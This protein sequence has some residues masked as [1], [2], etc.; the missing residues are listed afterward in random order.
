MLES[1]AIMTSGGVADFGDLVLVLGDFHVPF[2]AQDVPEK[3]KALLVPN[4]MKHILCTGNLCTRQTM[5]YLRTIAPNVHAVRGEFDEDSALPDHKIVEIG[6]F[7]V[8]IIHGHQIVPWGDPEA[9]ANFQREIDVDILITGHTH[10]SEVYAYHNS[11]YIVNPGSITGA[12]SILNTSA[13]PSFVLMAIKGLKVSTYVYELK[14]G[15]V[16][17]SKSEFTKPNSTS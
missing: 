11:H 6:N 9:L 2:R 12:Y 1:S 15:E 3:F 16:S 14:N 13:N 4:K 5:E 7:K 10:S 8:G 17:V